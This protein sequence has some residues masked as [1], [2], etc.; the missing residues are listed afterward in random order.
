[1]ASGRRAVYGV[2]GSLLVAFVVLE[3]A[4][5]RSDFNFELVAG[6]LIDHDPALLSLHRDVVEPG[7][8]A[9]AVGHAARGFGPR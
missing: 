1:V 2:A 3:A 9:A 4:F 6:A 7:G 8:V 5:L